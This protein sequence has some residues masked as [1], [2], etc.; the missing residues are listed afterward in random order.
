MIQAIDKVAGG[1]GV[2]RNKFKN[3]EEGMT[4][5]SFDNTGGE[6]H[7]EGWATWMTLGAMGASALVLLIWQ[8][9]PLS[10]VS[11]PQL[12]IGAQDCAACHTGATVLPS[13]VL[14]H[15][16]VGLD[17]VLVYGSQAVH[18]TQDCASCHATN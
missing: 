3:W 10:G 13:V 6:P 12:A 2:A 8:S 15:A 11:V 17:L 4:A 16:D 5:I 9:V 18:T 1:G 7:A 14:G